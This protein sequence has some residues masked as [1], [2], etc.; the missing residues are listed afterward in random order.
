MSSRAPPDSP[1]SR[2]DRMLSTAARTLADC[3]KST[4]A[5]CFLASMPTFAISPKGE[6]ASIRSTTLM[7]SGNPRTKTPMGLATPEPRQMDDLDSLSC[8]V[9]FLLSIVADW[10]DAGVDAALAAGGCLLY[11]PP[12]GPP[13]AI[14]GGMLGSSMKLLGLVPVPPKVARR[15][16]WNCDCNCIC[17]CCCCCCCSRGCWTGCGGSSANALGE[18]MG[19]SD[20][21]RALVASK[22][23]RVLRRWLPRS[24]CWIGN[25]CCGGCCCWKGWMRFCVSP[26]TAMER[27]R[28]RPALYPVAGCCCC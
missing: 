17:C 10:P 21:K 24:P 28:R 11:K 8:L 15:W 14:G 23:G 22:D 3:S 20:K 19:R 9:G 16:C 4:Y 5:N 12:E 7:D 18:D 26:M 1:N 6:K 27:A 13:G 25:C 2:V